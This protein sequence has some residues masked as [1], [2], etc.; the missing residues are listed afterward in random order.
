MA[1]VT[2]NTPTA[3]RVAARF[4]EAIQLA[5]QAFIDELHQLVSHLSE[6]LTGQ[7]DSGGLQSNT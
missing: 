2:S 1:Q 7:V 4:D 5:E 6:R 3:M